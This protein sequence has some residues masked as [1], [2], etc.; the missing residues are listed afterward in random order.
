MQTPEAK[1]APRLLA[2]GGTQDGFR[3]Q[4]GEWPDVK[5]GAL[6]DLHGLDGDKQ[7]FGC[8]ILGG[9]PTL[10]I[11]ER[12]NPQMRGGYAYSLLLDPGVETWQCVGWNPARLA[13]ALFGRSSGIGRGL[14][15]RPESVSLANLS[16][17]MADAARIAVPHTAA[18]VELASAF[19]ALWVGASLASGRL[20]VDPRK[21]G[22]SSCPSIEDVASVLEGL[23]PCLRIGRGWLIGGGEAHAEA[24]GA[25]FALA[26]D[27]ETSEDTEALLARGE[28]VLHALRI[29]A[30]EAAAAAWIEDQ[31]HQPFLNWQEPPGSF[32][33]DLILLGQLLGVPSPDEAMVARVEEKLASTN[34]LGQAIV[35]AA[36]TKLLSSRTTLG[37]RATYFV[38][39]RCLEGGTALSPKQT[40]ILHPGELVAQFTHRQL[41]PNRIRERIDLP[42]GVRIAVWQHLAEAVPPE[43][44]PEV[45]REA[46]SDLSDGDA[47]RDLV[48]ILQ[49]A[50]GRA[51]GQTLEFAQWGRLRENTTV[52]R[53]VARFLVEEARQGAKERR[54]PEWALEYFEYAEDSGGMHAGFLPDGAATELVSTILNLLVGLSNAKARKWLEELARSPLRARLPLALKRQLATALGGPWSPFALLVALFEGQTP[55]TRRLPELSEDERAHLISE[56]HALVFEA[57]PGGHAPSLTELYNWLP[58]VPEP[59]RRK[60]AALE[61]KPEHGKAESWILG[62]VKSGDAERAVKETIR[63][64]EAI[65]PGVRLDQFSE[66]FQQQVVRELLSCGGERADVRYTHILASL[67]VGSR[68]S[69][70]R[71]VVAAGPAPTLARRL[72]ADGGLLERILGLLTR[73]DQQT[74]VESVARSS[75]E[76]FRTLARNVLYA[77]QQGRAEPDLNFTERSVLHVLGS[78]RSG[79]TLEELATR[80]FGEFKAEAVIRNVRV[81]FHNNGEGEA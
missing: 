25:G 52:G 42:P 81:L 21:I 34:P 37:R 59:L 9:V 46:V 67:L 65:P 39:A 69:V 50:I 48:S 33:D 74:V 8:G 62:L 6:G 64:L 68:M 12:Q 61:P 77:V 71:A 54:R 55:P 29:V 47:R 7:E 32:F 27:L 4:L 28:S 36:E 49:A 66:S 60:L 11:R 19:E 24:F 58:D 78:G 53:E 13:S 14:L 23:P 10:I 5:V 30:T 44:L 56:L 3:H 57:K 70:A 2:Y 43:R 79:L 72:A 22:L 76:T 26:D 80:V 75:P 18:P 63:A 51:Q 41:F 17:L 38:L 15:D 16:E 73:D 45:V 40:S 1:S 35:Q 20:L 31:L